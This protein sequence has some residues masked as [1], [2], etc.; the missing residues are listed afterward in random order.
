MI[1]KGADAWHSGHV[2]D[3]IEFQDRHARVVATQTGGVWMIDNDN[4]TVQLSDT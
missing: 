3:I 1:D 4:N 2:S